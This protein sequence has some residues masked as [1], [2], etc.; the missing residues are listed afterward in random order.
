MSEAELARGRRRS[1]VVVVSSFPVHP[2][3]FG[4]Q[5]R[6]FHT[7]RQLAALADVHI[8]SLTELGQRSAKY[9][10]GGGVVETVVAK[11]EAHTAIERETDDRAGLPVGDILAAT[12]TDR[13]PEY[14]AALTTA[15]ADAD[16]VL[17]VHPYLL[18]SVRA[19]RPDTPILYDAHNAELRHKGALLPES[20]ERAKL[21]QTVREVEAQACDEAVLVS[22][23]DGRD[24]DA[25]AEDYS[26]PRDRI[27]V[28][29]Q[30]ADTDGVR[31]TGGRA[32]RERRGRWL[33]AIPEMHGGGDGGIAVFIGSNHR[34]N[35]EACAWIVETAP[36]MPDT[37]FVVA[38]GVGESF[39]WTAVPSNLLV[40][41]WVS[42]TVKCGLLAA[43][44]VALNPM[45]SGYGSNVKVPDYLAAGV[46]VVTTP[47][48]ARGFAL[49]DGVHAEI[50]ELDALEPA[51]AG[52]RDDPVRA[53]AMAAAGRRLVEETYSWPAVTGE[54]R[55]RVAGLLGG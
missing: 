13:T 24:A 49:T 5:I 40:A 14:G 25:L 42:D 34:P 39:G 38:G 31:F 19:I 55:R 21:L 32:R 9:D 27:V 4:G 46:P 33:A 45:Q 53:D 54:W 44:T 16:A 35:V 12:V 29:P 48:G 6:A 8:V 51:I 3:V 30:G 41:G 7:A 22:V 15:L 23:P 28:M 37:T 26:V 36:R 11:S 2:K 50:R 47:F 17:L 18:P 20:S 1:R 10:L 52:L 43:A